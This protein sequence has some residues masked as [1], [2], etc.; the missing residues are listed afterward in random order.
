[1]QSNMNE[2]E[3]NRNLLMSL[4]RNTLHERNVLRGKS[5]ENKKTID[6]LR[7]IC[8]LLLLF[9]FCKYCLV[10]LGLLDFMYFFCSELFV[11][12][13]FSKVNFTNFQS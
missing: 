10:F 4:Q 11:I 2:V 9:I 7:L 12:L 1:M 3:E 13:R 8:G 5:K 6:H